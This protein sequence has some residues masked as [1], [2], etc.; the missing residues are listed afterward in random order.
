VDD[1]GFEKME[2]YQL[3]SQ[4]GVVRVANMVDPNFTVVA[5]FPKAALP[6]NIRK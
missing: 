5:R 6:P 2:A 4:V 3:V 1:Y